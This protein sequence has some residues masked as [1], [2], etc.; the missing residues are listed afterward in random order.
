MVR[1]DELRQKAREED[2]DL[3][4][5]EIAGNALAKGRR[6]AGRGPRRGVEGRVAARSA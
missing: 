1:V 5:Q 2:R 6:A 4:I 3:R